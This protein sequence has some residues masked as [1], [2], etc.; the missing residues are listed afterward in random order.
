MAGG[1]PEKRAAWEM[2]DIGG[3]GVEGRKKAENMCHQG[4]CRVCIAGSATTCMLTLQ[5]A[6]VLQQLSLA[7][8]RVG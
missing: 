8:S 1:R 4:M 6:A 2:A 7:S 3:M 5:R